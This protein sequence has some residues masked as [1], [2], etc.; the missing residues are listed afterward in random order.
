MYGEKGIVPDY[1]NNILV[2]LSIGKA[3]NTFFQDGFW[4]VDPKNSRDTKLGVHS[5]ES[6]MMVKQNN[7]FGRVLFFILLFGDIF[8]IYLLK[9]G[10]NF[11]LH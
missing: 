1:N 10:Y 6:L 2:I 4:K 8:N 3:V 5:R 11:Y 9:N 7:V